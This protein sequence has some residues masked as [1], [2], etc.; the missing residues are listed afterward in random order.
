MPSPNLPRFVG[1][2]FSP[3]WMARQ[4]KDLAKSLRTI[5]PHKTAG[6]ASPASRDALQL[7]QRRLK[8]KSADYSDMLQG[9]SCA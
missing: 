5:K 8:R 6:G 7:T 1:R 3:T 2:Q 9:A 4:K